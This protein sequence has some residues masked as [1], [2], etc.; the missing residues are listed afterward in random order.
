[1]RPTPR[2]LPGGFAA[3]K[4]TAPA[5]DVARRRGL[6]PAAVIRFDANVPPLPGVPRIPL[7][8]SFARLNEYPPGGYR[9]LHAAA[10]SY[11]G[12]RPEQILSLIHI[13]EPTRLGMISYAVFCLKKKK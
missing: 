8:E 9:E 2:P 4:W 3:Y 13:S 11:V 7:G 10:A 6:D 1:M 12:A 5:E